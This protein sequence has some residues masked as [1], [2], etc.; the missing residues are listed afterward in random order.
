[1]PKNEAA[2]NQLLVAQM[3]DTDGIAEILVRVGFL[4][5]DVAARE[6]TRLRELA[7]QDGPPGT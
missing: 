5:A 4:D 6:V 1:M 7:P 3:N 2:V